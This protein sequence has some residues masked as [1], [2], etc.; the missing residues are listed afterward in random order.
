MKFKIL[1]FLL[2]V[3]ISACSQTIDKKKI[4]D[5]ISYI[6]NNNR[7]IGS[8]SIFKDGKEVYNR[9][10]GQKALENVVYD[11]NTKYQIGSITKMVTATLIFRLIE[12]GERS[13]EHTSELQSLMS[14][15]YAVFCLK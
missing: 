3:T 13:E 9:S 10:F 11:E 6:E 12:K 7:G 8:V 14:I 1:F 15:S 4:D 5:Y 2:L